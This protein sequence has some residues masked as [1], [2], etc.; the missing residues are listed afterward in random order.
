MTTTDEHT[1]RNR[2]PAAPASSPPRTSPIGVNGI[3]LAYRRFGDNQ[4]DAPPLRLLQH[5]RSN[6]NN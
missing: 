3:S 4:A 6:L 5:F 2:R 1:T